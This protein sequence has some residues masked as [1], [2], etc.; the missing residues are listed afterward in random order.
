MGWWSEHVVPRVTDASL[1][2]RALGE[3]R[4]RAC[5]GL[6]GRVLEIGFGG[7]LNLVHLPAEVT[8]VGAVEPSDVGWRLSEKRRSASVV[9]VVRIGLDGQA[10]AA[11]DASYDSAL[12]TFTLCTIPDALAALSE[13]RRVVRP[14]GTLHFLEH[15][16]SPDDRVAGWQHRLDPWQQRL[17]GGCHLTRD[18]G[19]LVEQSGMTLELLETGSLPGF[20]GPAALSFGFLGRARV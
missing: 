14:G 13:V 5:A 18:A 4:S 17:A 16:L 12:C 15:G 19:A 2:G 1:R 10:I 3:S 20:S 9:P 11:A 6:T 8:E 7:G